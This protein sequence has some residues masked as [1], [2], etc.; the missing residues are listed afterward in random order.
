MDMTTVC[1]E[2]RKLG[3]RL[4]FT[5]M[6]QNDDFLTAISK[7][8]EPILITGETGT[9]KEFLARAIHN[10][11]ERTGNI[12]AV[13][14]GGLNDNLVSADLFGS[15][16]GGFTGAI[17]KKGAVEEA[18]RGTLFLDEIGDASRYI[19]IALLRF[20]NS[21]KK[22]IYLFNRVGEEGQELRK[23]HIRIIFA[24]NK[25]LHE[26]I[27][28]KKFRL[29]FY[30]RISTFPVTMEAMPKDKAKKYK[31][32]EWELGT[33]AKG[34]LPGQRISHDKQQYP[35]MVALIRNDEK[36]FT[37]EAKK[38][39]V[40]YPFPGNRR[41]LNSILKYSLVKSDAEFP[42]RKKHI[43]T[44]DDL[45][46]NVLA[47]GYKQTPDNI[48]LDTPNENFI[49]KLNELF[50]QKYDM[51]FKEYNGNKSKVARA[52]GLPHQNRLETLINRRGL[53]Q[54]KSE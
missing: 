9:G 46:P 34:G 8:T 25:D 43:I 50:M 21:G 30:N 22:G 16:V 6:E 31:L 27:R 14:C 54:I 1:S 10:T 47:G 17:D 48:V 49:Q 2:L 39:L 4:K 44:K 41:E 37:A 12:V 7:T 42:K 3:F 5:T 51:L 20:L 28:K 52:L 13:N 19:Q 23:S 11:S 36:P 26:Q 15:V 18:D 24:T 33:L 40:D 45:H 32:I 35:K 53:Y 29:D 38:M